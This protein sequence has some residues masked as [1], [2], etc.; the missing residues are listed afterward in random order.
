MM[1]KESR[2]LAGIILITYP[3][4]ALGGYSLLS[5]LLDP[6][7]GYQAT[8]YMQD[9]YRAGHA[10]A[11]VLLVLSLVLLR[12]VDEALLNDKTKAFVRLASP[13]AA[14]FMSAGFFLSLIPMGSPLP[15]V[16]INLVYL[17]MAVLVTG[18]VV[19]GV[20]LLRN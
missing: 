2:R 15:N 3:S 18:F 8:P 16:L 20:G 19:L 1:S 9:L 11:A 13:L 6:A 17:G 5:L 4:V 10:H 7:S 14:I 12:Y